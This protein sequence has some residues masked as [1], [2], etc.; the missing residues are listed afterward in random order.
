MNTLVENKSRVT[1]SDTQVLVTKTCGQCGILFAIPHTFDQENHLYGDKRT[2][3]CPNGHPRVYRETE[4]QRLRR[5]M[6][7]KLADAQREIEDQK[8]WKDRERENR[9]RAERQ[10]VAAKGRITKLTK[11]V[12]NGVCPCCNRSFSNLQRHMV[13]QHPEFTRAD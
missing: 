4:V 3:Y 8:Q 1:Y 7:A 9:L 10:H 2:W 13:G 12:G 11:R 6:E 5:E